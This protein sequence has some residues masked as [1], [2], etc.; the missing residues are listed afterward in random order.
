MVSHAG[1]HRVLAS[2]RMDMVL[3]YGGARL[4]PATLMSFLQKLGDERHISHGCGAAMRRVDVLSAGGRPN[5]SHYEGSVHLAPTS[6]PPPTN[7]LAPYPNAYPPPP[8]P[9]PGAGPRWLR[10]Y[11]PRQ[12]IIDDASFISQLVLQVQCPTVSCTSLPSPPL[13]PMANVVAGQIPSFPSCAHGG[14]HGG[15]LWWRG[16]TW[17]LAAAAVPSGWVMVGGRPWSTTGWWLM[18]DLVL[19]FLGSEVTEVLV[20]L[21]LF[22]FI[23]DL[24]CRRISCKRIASLFGEIIL[25]RASR[26]LVFVG[27]FVYAIPCSSDIIYSHGSVVTAALLDSTWK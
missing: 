8:P 23:I 21:V 14:L 15:A 7:A 9:P 17:R 18:P 20:F 24:L 22:R 12:P 10:R 16:D 5:R 3:V 26:W 2:S 4:D 19:V 6:P 25:F 13:P 11:L 1:V 27:L